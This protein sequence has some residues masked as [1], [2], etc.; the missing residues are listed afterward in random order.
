MKKSVLSILFMAFMLSA[1]A[2]YPKVTI[3]E[4]QEVSASDLA[5]CNGT[6]PY[7]NDTVTIV[8]YVVTDGNLSEVA[9][10]SVAGGNRPFLFLND[11][12][13]NG[14]VG[15]WTGIEMMGAYPTSTG[16][17]PITNIE[18]LT[19]GDM[20]ELTVIV[21]E[22]EGSTQVEP[23]DDNSFSVI[24]TLTPNI[25]VPKV[26]VGD[27][28]DDQRVNQLETG[29]QWEGV[30]IKLENVTVTNVNLFSGNSRVSFDVADNQGNVINV[31]DRFLAQRMTAHNVVNPNSPNSAANGGPG[32]GTFTPPTVGTF[33]ESL[34]GVARQ[35]QN[36]CAGSGRG[37]E[38]NPFD[39]SHYQVGIPRPVFSNT[40]RNPLVPNASQSVTVS[41]DVTILSGTVDTVTMF[42]TND[43]TLPVS[44]YSSVIMSAS[45]ETYSG[46]IPANPNGTK[47]Y[48]FF[49]AKASNGETGQFPITPGSQSLPNTLFYT[50]RANGL[51]IM[52]IQE[53]SNPNVSDA[54]P[55]LGE[56]VTI[57]GV[58]TAS[59]ETS[60]LGSV[61][62]QDPSSNEWS[63]IF[64][65]GSP[66]L[67]ALAVG[68]VATVTGT[69]QENFGFTRIDV[70]S[71]V[72]TGTGTITPV[73]LD[74][75]DA[76]LVMEVYE[77]MLVTFA[78]P[79]TGGKIFVTNENA[80]APS[81]FGEFTVGSD[82]AATTSRRVLAGRSSGSSFSSLNFSLI[83]NLFYATGQGVMNV[84]AVIAN[85][86]MEMDSLRGVVHYGFSN[87]KLTPRNNGDLFGLNVPLDPTPINAPEALDA[88]LISDSS[89]LANWNAGSAATDF[90]L[91]V[92]TNADLSN[93]LS[94]YDGALINGLAENVEGLDAETNYYYAL[95]AVSPNPV[96]L[97]NSE[98]SNI[99][100]VITLVGDTSGG[101]TS[102]QN[103]ISNNQEIV[104]YPNPTVSDVRFNFDGIEGNDVRLSISD[105]QGKVVK[106]VNKLQMNVVSLSDL[107]KGIYTI[108]VFSGDTHLG[109]AKVVLTK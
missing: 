61:Y 38:L 48:Y 33:Y 45:N 1:F 10:G 31:S 109:Y 102:I 89:F 103:L 6:T 68:D 94:N 36:G 63:G 87:Y 69:V 67:Q 46:T 14:E 47:M 18:F 101:G 106:E 58:V 40:T 5:N 13:N 88:T 95:V 42:Y 20:I 3:K 99:I 23:I 41:V 97:A 35:S 7:L 86:S 12:A 50:V 64:L 21:K 49:T 78:N 19:Q 107:P 76:T 77:S 98:R 71:A 83:T 34:K 65:F 60:N 92:S 56:T 73:V 84:P 17:V 26:P 108:S 51:T 104:I 96:A 54:S 25:T 43:P 29:E 32:T 39:D 59:Q 37:Y 4:I 11:T 52:D 74:P 91:T 90:E 16:L 53:V 66:S 62:I 24:G 8:C 70:S 44:S 9:S 85:T 100:N 93:P 82:P 105:I 30:F 22:F 28:N 81:N 57:S 27:L 55:L 15:P 2:Q 72:K 75:S 80:D 79:T